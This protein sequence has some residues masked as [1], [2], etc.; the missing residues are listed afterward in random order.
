MTVVEQNI[1]N[2][3]INIPRADSQLFMGVCKFLNA[4]SITD[5]E[6]AH[7]AT[8]GEIDGLN[9][10]DKDDQGT[11]LGPTCIPRKPRISL[12]QNRMEITFFNQ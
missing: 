8:N 5:V 11:K 6:K 1:Q 2:T 9:P 12:C 4:L 7:H 3:G 10:F